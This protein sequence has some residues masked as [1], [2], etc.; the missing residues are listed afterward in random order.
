MSFLNPVLDGGADYIHRALRCGSRAMRQLPSVRQVQDVA[1]PIL[2]SMATIDTTLGK[3]AFGAAITAVTVS[4]PACFDSSGIIIGR[5]FALTFATGTV[6]GAASYFGNAQRINNPSSFE[7][8]TQAP[9]YPSVLDPGPLEDPLLDGSV[10]YGN[11]PMDPNSGLYKALTAGSGI[12]L[13]GG[14]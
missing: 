5:L 14:P 12:R 1:L 2:Q 3:L 9:D 11:R 7:N 6:A 8:P 10:M 4:L 13:D